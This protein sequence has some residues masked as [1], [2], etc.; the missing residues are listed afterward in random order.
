[1]FCD[2]GAMSMVERNVSIMN[3]NVL[4][5]CCDEPNGVVDHRCLGRSI[6]P[7][8]RRPAFTQDVCVRDDLV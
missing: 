5:C 2:D 1:M 4:C 3:F 7:E 8:H 6:F